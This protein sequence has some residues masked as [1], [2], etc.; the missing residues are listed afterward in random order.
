MVKTK[1]ERKIES[2]E[3]KELEKKRPVTAK[4]V[5]PKEVWYDIT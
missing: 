4:S 3:V 1:S 5:T 2:K